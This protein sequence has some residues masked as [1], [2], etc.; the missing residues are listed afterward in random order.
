MEKINECVVEYG[1]KVNEK[2]SKVVCINGEV[3]RRRW[4]IGECCIGE[5]EE[6]KYLGITI[7]RGKHVYYKLTLTEVLFIGDLYRKKL[8]SLTC[9]SHTTAVYILVTVKFI[10][11]FL[12]HGCYNYVFYET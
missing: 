10:G 7:E 4:M 2:K 5:V 6:Y 8:C 12:I 9:L 11:I 3:G 1:L